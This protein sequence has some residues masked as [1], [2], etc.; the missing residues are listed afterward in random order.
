MTHISRSSI[1]IAFFFG[2]DKVFGLL[3]Q[4]LIGREFGLTYQID[5]FNAANNIPDLLGAL[6]SGGALGV[7]LIPVLSEYMEKRGLQD[8]WDLFSRVLN[9]AF[10]V[11]GVLAAIAAIFALPFIQY[12]IAP[13]LPAEYQLLAVSLMRLDLFAIMIFSISGLVMAGLQANQHFFLPALA[14]TLY[15]V[16]Q[17]FGVA[18][19]APQGAHELFGI[20]LP[21]YGFGIYGLVYG[22]IIG[23]ALHLLIQVPGLRKHQ[24]RWSWGIGLKTPGMA[25]VLKLLGPRVAT[26][27]FIFWFFIIRDRLASGLGEGAITALNNGW[28]IMQVPETLIGTALAIAILP[29]LSEHVARKDDEAYRDTINRAIRIL[30]SITIP[31]A[32]ILSMGVAPLVSVLGFEADGSL[33]VVIATRA[34]LLGLAGHTLLE[35]AS[36][37]LYARQ[38]AITPL[39]AAFLN[40]VLY[41]V[42]AITLSRL[43]GFVGVALANSIAFTIEA[44]ILLTVL[45]R[46]IP[47][48]WK[49]DKTLF[50]AVFAAVV[51]GGAVYLALTYL[52]FGG[53]PGPITGLIALAIGVIAALPFVWQEVRLLGKI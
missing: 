3:R 34:Y 2:I 10:V 32:A 20:T 43:W 18:I 48:I 7:A 50:R 37:S 4:I 39:W 36:R 14:P 46:R 12:V 35:I 38:D 41:T 25:Q 1:L 27:F 26:K 53:L 24:Y 42:I 21:G 6:I 31:A 51:G 17:I 23:A 15:N 45:N 47:G 44:I 8:A 11:T 19:L 16:G 9:L 33:L 49:V 28:F 5:A 52:P 29:T 13:N 22:V 30:L 40:A